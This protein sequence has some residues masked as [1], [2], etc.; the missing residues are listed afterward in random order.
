VD[1]HRELLD[2]GL[3][4][5]S[6]KQLQTTLDMPELQEINRGLWA[7]TRDL[8]LRVNDLQMKLDAQEKRIPETKQLREKDHGEEIAF[9]TRM[10]QVLK[11]QIDMA[12]AQK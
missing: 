3:D 2:A 6:R 12:A 10:G 7:L 11:G 8:V 4:W 5:T 9:L 1:A